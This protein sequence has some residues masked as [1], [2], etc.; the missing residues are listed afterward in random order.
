MHDT[1]KKQKWHLNRE[2]SPPFQASAEIVNTTSRLDIESE[3][4][5]PVVDVGQGYKWGV[6][7]LKANAQVY[8][9]SYH[10]GEVGTN[11]L[12]V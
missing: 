4:S 10:L 12:A 11:H 3:G 2:R 7:L 6:M 9:A 5:E 1:T 8:E